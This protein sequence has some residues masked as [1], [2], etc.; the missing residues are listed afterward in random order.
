MR[1]FCQITIMT[2]FAVILAFTTVSCKKKVKKIKV[3]NQF[4]VSLFDDTITLREILNDMDSTAKQWLRVRNDSIFI[5]YSDSINVVLNARELLSQNSIRYPEARSSIFVPS[6]GATS[7]NDTTIAFHNVIELDFKFDEFSIDSVVFRS[8]I[9][10]LDIALD[11]II[12]PLEKVEIYSS[13][14]FTPDNDTLVLTYDNNHPYVH[15]PFEDLK[16]APEGD[17]VIYFGVKIVMND[18]YP[19]GDHDII[20]S[21]S[22]DDIMFKTLYA[23]VNKDLDSLFTADTEINFGV[24]GLTGESF[25]LPNPNIDITYRNS[26][27]IQAQLN[28]NKL[29][30]INENNGYVTDLILNYPPILIDTT[31]GA[32]K[33]FKFPDFTN[34]L[35]A[36]AGYTR[37][38]FEGRALLPETSTHISIS[39]TSELD[40]IADIEMP[41]SFNISDLHYCDT[42]E[43]DLGGNDNNDVGVDDYFDEVDFFIDYVNTI[44]L[45]IDMQ[46]VFLKDGAASDSLFDNTQHIDF[47]LTNHHIPTGGTLSCYVT[48]D[49]DDPEHS[50]LA[51]IMQADHMVLRLGVSTDGRNVNINESDYIK[52]RLRIL[53]HTTEINIDND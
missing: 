1:R 15:L 47:D 17:T 25:M 48:T 12:A 29:Q 43:L 27:G 8:G 2:I 39:D 22:L 35:N 4:A 31:H 37:L 38:N 34:Q 36:L 23:Q 21:G 28:I 51:H 44:P 52:L 50:K 16:V 20:Y 46:G 41:L 24:P 30:F 33:S 32:Y 40:I 10:N 5:Y 53:T 45:R 19:G 13:Q 6:F 18:Y 9:L 3:D 42:V 14:L 26:F 7:G 49:S 11:P